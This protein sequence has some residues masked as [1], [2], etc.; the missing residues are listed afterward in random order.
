M[1]YRVFL[2]VAETQFV[3]TPLSHTSREESMSPDVAQIAHGG[4]APSVEGNPWDQSFDLP[5]EAAVTNIQISFMPF[6]TRQRRIVH[7]QKF[8][9]IWQVFRIEG[10][11]GT[12]GRTADQF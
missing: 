8:L 4:P 2:S 10:A 12:L 11:G 6:R 3:V 1:I 5:F 9:R 7:V